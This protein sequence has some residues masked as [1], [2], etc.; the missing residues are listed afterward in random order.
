MGVSTSGRFCLSAGPWNEKL[1]SVFVQLRLFYEFFGQMLKFS[2][3]AEAWGEKKK[4]LTFRS[5][6]E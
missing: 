1:Q 4:K 5:R 2:H 6:Y 3:G